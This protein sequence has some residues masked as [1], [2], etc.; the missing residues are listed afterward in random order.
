MPGGSSNL[1][2]YEHPRVTELSEQMKVT[3]DLEEKKVMSDEVVQIMMGVHP[4]TGWEGIAPS[5][6]VMNPINHTVNWPWFRPD[7][8]IYQFAHAGHRYDGTWLDTGH[9]DYPA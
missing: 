4:D 6:G 9:P 5:I 8:D 3:L 1:Y 2:H 7:P